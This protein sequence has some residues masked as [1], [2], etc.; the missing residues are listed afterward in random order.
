MSGNIV[1]V[2]LSEDGL[3]KLPRRVR[4]HTAEDDLEG[5]HTCPTGDSSCRAE[6]RVQ[7]LL[8]QVR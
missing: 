8:R 6:S 5:K 7:R 2:I 1:T 3:R 4:G